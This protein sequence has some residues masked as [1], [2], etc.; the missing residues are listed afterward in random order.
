[1]G[2]R[3]LESWGIKAQQDQWQVLQEGSWEKYLQ[4]HSGYSGR[5]IWTLARSFCFVGRCWRVINEME[6]PLHR[7]GIMELFLAAEFKTTEGEWWTPP[8]QSQFHSKMLP[9]SKYLLVSLLTKPVLYWEKW[10]ICVFWL[11]QVLCLSPLRRLCR[12]AGGLETLPFLKQGTEIPFPG[13][14][15]GQEWGI[16][17]WEC[18]KSSILLVLDL[19]FQVQGNMWFF[20][21]I[22]SLFFKHGLCFLRF[23]KI[24]WF[25]I[26]FYGLFIAQP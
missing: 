10:T 4:F 14:L 24:I 8:S 3:S 6:Q 25:W 2:P 9:K 22:T 20:F 16:P 17:T 11:N 21:L 15:Q 7:L 12:G 1:M 19:C 26:S 5:S 18:Q 23:Y 13:T